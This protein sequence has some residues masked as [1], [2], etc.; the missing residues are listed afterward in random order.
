MICEPLLL[1]LVWQITFQTWAHVVWHAPVR[2]F[3]GSGQLQSWEAMPS[4][5]IFFWLF[6]VDMRLFSQKNFV[7]QVVLWD[8]YNRHNTPRLLKRLWMEHD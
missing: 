6:V 7:R 1:V 2:G 3:S 5:A 8:H 4:W